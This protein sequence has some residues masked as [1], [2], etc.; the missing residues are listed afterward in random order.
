[1][2]RNDWLSATMVNRRMLRAYGEKKR[3][4]GSRMNLEEDQLPEIARTTFHSISVGT[5][6]RASH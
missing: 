3:E 4:L 6:V 5:Q 2:A 1:M